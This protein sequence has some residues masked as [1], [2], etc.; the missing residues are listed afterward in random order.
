MFDVRLTFDLSIDLHVQ[1]RQTVQ[2]EETECGK[3]GD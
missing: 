1:S 3:G 2:G